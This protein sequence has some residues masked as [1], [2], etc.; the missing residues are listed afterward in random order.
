MA[1]RKLGKLENITNITQIFFTLEFS[2]LPYKK[3][4]KIGLKKTWKKIS[5][6]SKF[7]T[8]PYF[9]IHSLSTLQS[10]EF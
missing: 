4:R 5:E 1:N 2:I 6:I 9:N 10:I 8:Q 3:N 7:L